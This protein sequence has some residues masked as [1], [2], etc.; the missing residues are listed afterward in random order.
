MAQMQT[1]KIIGMYYNMVPYYENIIEMWFWDGD[2]VKLAHNYAILQEIGWLKS[3]ADNPIVC[4]AFGMESFIAVVD[5]YKDSVAIIDYASGKVLKKSQLNNPCQA[6]TTVFLT[7]SRMKSTL[8]T[9]PKMGLIFI[10][11]MQ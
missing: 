11:W 9:K 10:F 3:A 1:N 8:L 5:S 4:Q 7:T 2:L 6:N